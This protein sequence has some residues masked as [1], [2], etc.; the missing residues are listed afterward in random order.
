LTVC[1]LVGE[2]VGV[3]IH[4]DSRGVL[5]TAARW[6]PWKAPEVDA[7]VDLSLARR[8]GSFASALALATGVLEA[9]QRS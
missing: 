2:C 5:E 6:R 1:E 3:G 8:G 9:F 4:V 7:D